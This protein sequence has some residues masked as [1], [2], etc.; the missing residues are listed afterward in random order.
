LILCKNFKDC[1]MDFL[2]RLQEACRKC[3]SCEHRRG[4]DLDQSCAK[5]YDPFKC[6]IGD[7]VV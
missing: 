2:E 7:S 1:G 4:Q 5:N 6:P 3:Q